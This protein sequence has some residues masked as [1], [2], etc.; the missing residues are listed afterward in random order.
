MIKKVFTALTLFLFAASASAQAPV[1]ELP[2]SPYASFRYYRSVN[3]PSVVVPTVTEVSVADIPVERLQYA[4]ADLTSGVQE[5]Y[6]LRQEISFPVSV[7]SS[8]DGSSAYLM[9]DNDG[10]TYSEFPLYESET[11]KAS[12]TLT[13]SS[14]VRSSA[15]TILLDNNVALPA[16]VEIKA[17]VDGRERVVVAR[18]KMTSQLISFP[19]TV[20]SKWTIN[21]EY[22]QPLR[23]SEIY[24][25]Q[26]NSGISGRVI[27]F[28]AQPNHTYRLYFDADRYVT[29]KVGESGNLATAKEFRTASLSFSENNPEYIIADGDKDTV[30]D[31]RDNCVSLAN[32]DQVDIDGNGRGDA[33]DDYDQDGLVNSKDNCPDAPNRN[34]ADEDGD[35]IGDACDGEESRITEKHAWLPWAGMG[36]AALVL[37]AL[38][39]VMA[40]STKLPG[41]E[42]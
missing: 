27:R 10:R 8:H 31:V 39:V 16:F 33:C 2:Q 12:V 1:A 28:L 25:S 15:M 38:F 24:L 36:F 14:P 19:T 18:K 41:S 30:P 6:Y 21:F 42:V 40:R 5:P 13:S 35:K 17:L 34:Q 3:V 20:S 37:L 9:G 29:P 7:S 4:I 23:I 26:D 32:A 22:N 11:G